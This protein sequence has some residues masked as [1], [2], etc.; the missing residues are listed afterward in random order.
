VL[1]WLLIQAVVVA[2]P[3]KQYY[4][5]WFLVASVF[6]F[7]LGLGLSR[8][9]GRASTP[10][11][12]AGCMAMLVQ[13]FG[14]A[15]SWRA[16]DESEPQRR[17][18]RWM[19]RVTL[20]EDHVAAASPLHPI[21]RPDVFSLWFNTFDPSGFDA[22]QVMRRIP[23]LHEIAEPARYREEL[24]QNPPALVVISGDWRPTPRAPGQQAALTEFFREHPY[25]AVRL[26]NTW[27]ALRP[28][29]YERARMAGWLPDDG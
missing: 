9:A 16:A 25:R 22:E 14:L 18:I 11:F 8:L 20:P 4:A 1:A 13:A 27:F 7:P 2:Y 5:P 24:R 19:D 28:D 3:F 6:A 21:D 12:L 10:L 17:L 23:S 29:R 15:Q 26:A